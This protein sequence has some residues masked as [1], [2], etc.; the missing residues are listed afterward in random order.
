MAVTEDDLTELERQLRERGYGRLVDTARA[1]HQPEDDAGVQDR[2]D[3]LLE[4]IAAAVVPAVRA[5]AA[6][7]RLLSE[8]EGQYEFADVQ[9]PTDAIRVPREPGT[10]A[11]LE[12]DAAELERLV[13]ELR[14]AADADEA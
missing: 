5:R 6:S 10:A 8:V 7:I 13:D 3:F 1:E 14:A 11:S 4:L 12:R 9:R 2:F